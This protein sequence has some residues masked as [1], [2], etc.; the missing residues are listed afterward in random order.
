MRP[1][2]CVAVLFCVGVVNA[3]PMWNEFTQGDLSDDRFAPTPFVLNPGSN[4]LF[5]V[6]DGDDGQGNIDRDYFSLTIAEGYTLSRIDL[7]VY[8]SDDFAAFVGVQPGPIFPNDPDTVEPGDLLGWTLFGPSDIGADLL[9]M[10]GSNGQTFAPPLP[11]GTYSFW[12]QQIDSFTEW[13]PDFVVEP[14]PAPGG[15]V[16]VGVAG[17]ATL[18]RRR[19]SA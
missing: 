7:L 8:L 1:F 19:R 10:I 2:A 4:V 15:V 12:A 13:V 6:I 3:Q 11:A 14:V 17:L 5:G 9:P 18:S 16:L